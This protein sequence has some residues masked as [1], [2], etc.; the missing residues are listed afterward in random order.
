LTIDRIEKAKLELAHAIAARER[1]RALMDE[2]AGETSERQRWHWQQRLDLVLEYNPHL[3]RCEDPTELYAQ[4]SRHVE[5][6][7]ARLRALGFSAD[8]PSRSTKKR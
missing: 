6:S 1:L 7:K 5:D 4:Q 3:T 8:E 2:A